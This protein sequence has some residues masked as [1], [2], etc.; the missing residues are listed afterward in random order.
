MTRTLIGT[1]IS[2]DLAAEAERVTALLRSDAPRSEKIEEVDDLIIQL[3]QVGIDVHFHGPAQLFGLST[4]L[5][6]VIDV[7]AATT[8]RALKTATRRVL[9]GLS[10]EQL[11][12]LADEVEGRLYQF[13]LTE[14]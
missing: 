13:E 12:A 9:K 2:D 5:V 6:K 14:E 11:V 10:D 1:P 7:A 4:F 8:L 3:V